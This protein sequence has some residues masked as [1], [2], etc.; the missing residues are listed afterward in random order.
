MKKKRIL[1]ELKRPATPQQ[2]E[3]AILAALTPEVTELF[4]TKET[5]IIEVNEEMPHPKRE[6]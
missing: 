4:K 3:Q 2:A 1:V 5:V 6:R